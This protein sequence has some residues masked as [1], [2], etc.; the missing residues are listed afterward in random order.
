MSFPTD[1]EKYMSARPVLS[2]GSIYGATDHFPKTKDAA[3]SHSENGY[4]K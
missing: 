1:L 2:L 3:L 4:A